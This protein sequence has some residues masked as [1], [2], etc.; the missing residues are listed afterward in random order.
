MDLSDAESVSGT[1][2]A[3]V[4]VEGAFKRLR[5]GGGITEARPVEFVDK[6]TLTGK[7][8][9]IKEFLPIIGG[10]NYSV[11]IH[12]GAARIRL[13]DNEYVSAADG[14]GRVQTFT[15][16]N[17]DVIIVDTDG[18]VLPGLSGS[19]VYSFADL[20]ISD[21][22][23]EK[24][25]DGPLILEIVYEHTERE[26]LSYE[27]YK[28]VRKHSAMLRDMDQGIDLIAPNSM[29]GGTDVSQMEKNLDES[30][31]KDRVKIKGYNTATGLEQIDV[32][33]AISNS[34]RAG[35]IPILVA[36]K[37]SIKASAQTKDTELCNAM[38]L[39]R[40]ISIPDLKN[41]DSEAWFFAEDIARIALLQ[42]NLK[43]SDI[44]EKTSF[45]SDMQKLMTLLTGRSVAMEDLFLMLPFTDE[46]I[47]A[48]FKVDNPYKWMLQS[49]ER[50]L[51][52]MPMIPYDAKGEFEK[53]LRIMYAA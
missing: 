15:A 42:A 23:L 43:A 5:E 13:G 11:I 37:S 40:L 28:T 25:G 31:G 41:L 33:T 35:R 48:E 1:G 49:L 53:R 26:Q 14:Q 4:K 52:R 44:K 18:I 12:E 39:T 50:L 38:E 3:S 36:T 27:V 32:I 7:E 8:V 17:E 34:V 16:G 51:L 24:V 9:R 45:A 30:F 21:L 2:G 46:G 29:L 22:V 6:I 19:L 10:R 20:N 47:P